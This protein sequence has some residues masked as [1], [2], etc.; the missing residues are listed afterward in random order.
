MDMHELK[1]D[2]CQLATW[3]FVAHRDHELCLSPRTVPFVMEQGM[4]SLHGHCILKAVMTT[5]FTV[6]PLSVAN[7][8]STKDHKSSFVRTF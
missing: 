5:H 4:K 2:P 1:F 8:M 7:P 3:L 6:E